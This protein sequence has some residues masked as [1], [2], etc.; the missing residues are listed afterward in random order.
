MKKSTEGKATCPMC[1]PD[2]PISEIECHADICSEGFNFVGVVR[3]QCK[4]TDDND[5]HF[6]V[7]DKKNDVHDI[8]EDADGNSI[9]IGK[10]KDVVSHGNKMLT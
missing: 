8:V 9:W 7:V 5:G 2:F 1:Y 4:T 10:I 3:D 6:P